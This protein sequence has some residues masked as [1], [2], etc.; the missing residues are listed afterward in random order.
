MLTGE[1]HFSCYFKRCKKQI[2]IHLVTGYKLVQI[3]EGTDATLLYLPVGEI[4]DLTDQSPPASSW[5]A[6]SQ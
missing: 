2:G 3:G 4:H 6:P 5:A 1:G